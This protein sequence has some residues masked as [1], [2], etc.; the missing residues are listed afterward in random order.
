MLTLVGGIGLGLV[1][2]AHPWLCWLLILYLFA[3]AMLKL[4]A[5]LADAWDNKVTRD[6][7]DT[8]G[9][10]HL[11]A[12]ERERAWLLDVSRDMNRAR[13][14]GG[15]ACRRVIDRRQLP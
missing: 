4:V 12:V 9:Y 14:A 8:I 2:I 10:S 11:P 5:K 6:R 1:A 3:M 15:Q 7:R 13:L